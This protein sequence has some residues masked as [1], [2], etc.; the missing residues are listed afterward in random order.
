M[1]HFSGDR[2]IVSLGAKNCS[3]GHWDITGIPCIHGLSA[4]H[5]MRHDPADYVHPCFTVEA[6]RKA[7]SFG[8]QAIN[9]EKMWPKASGYPIEPPLIRKMPGRPKKKRIRD[10]EEK[11]PKNP[12]RLRRTGLQMTCQNCFQVGHN[13]RSCKN[14]KV[15]KPQKEQVVLYL[16]Y[17]CYNTLLLLLLFTYKTVSGKERETKETPYDSRI[18]KK[19]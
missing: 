13:A 10:K 8:L 6:Y 15:Q 19:G 2:F 1:K 18:N 4:I 9:G 11:D 3:C 17:V 16:E 7:Y 12:N 14:E 5:F